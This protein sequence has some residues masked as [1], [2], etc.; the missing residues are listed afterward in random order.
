MRNYAL[1]FEKKIENRKI[2]QVRGP[3]LDLGNE[4]AKPKDRKFSI[5]PT[6]NTHFA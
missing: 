5:L 3:Y 6:N 4:I 1:N 2:G